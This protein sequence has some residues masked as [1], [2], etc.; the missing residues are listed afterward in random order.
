MK[1]LIIVL[2]LV[3]SLVLVGCKSSEDEPTHEHEYINHQCSCGKIDPEYYVHEHVYEIT[4]TEATCTEDSERIY[5][6]FCGY[7]TTKIEKA[8]GHSYEEVG[9]DATCIEDGEKVCTCS[10]CGYEYT[11][12]IEATGHKYIAGKCS[13]CG[14]EKPGLHP[15]E[16]VDGRCTICDELEEDHQ[17][18]PKK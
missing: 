12:V 3:L 4:G 14:K 16:Y 7:V 17:G 8:K 6:C 18:L 11:K 2:S 9:P 10:V 15:H 5:T 13:V 1:K